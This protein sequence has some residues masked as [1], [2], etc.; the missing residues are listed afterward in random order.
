MGT[1]GSVYAVDLEKDLLPSLGGEGAFALQ[2]APHKAGAD[3]GGGNG[4]I[5]SGSEAPFL[6]FL[7]GDVDAERAGKALASL[8]GPIAEALNP[9][10]GPHAPSSS[11]HKVGDVTAHT[12]ALSG[13]SGSTL[14]HFRVKSRDAAGNLATS[15]DFTFTTLDATAPVISGVGASA[16][17]AT[18]ATIGWTTNEASDSQ[19]D[20]GLTTAYGNSS[21]LNTTGVSFVTLSGLPATIFINSA[22]SRDAAGNLAT[23]AT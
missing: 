19:V 14:Y 9:S 16:I 12:V 23:P 1:S 6:E 7:A 8:E 22:S 13:L 18:G 11:E 20:Y 2:Q 15:G 3:G 10:K 21:P 4:A 17:T 5:L